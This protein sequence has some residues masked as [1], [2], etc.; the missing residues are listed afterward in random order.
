[1]TV[2][3]V[4]ARD[5]D[6]EIVRNLVTFYIYD[7]SEFGRWD[8]NEKGTFGLPAGIGNYWSGGEGPHWKPHWQGFPFLVRVD[9][10]IAGFALVKRIAESPPAY[11]MGEFFILRKFRRSGVGEQTACT[12]FNRFR[13]QWDVR[14]MPVNLPAQNF[15]RR[16]IARYTQNDFT[17]ARE[18]FPEYG[19]EF[20]IQRFQS[21]G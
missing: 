2:E 7:L 3:L 9:G 16:I 19:A 10:E 6:I 11:D 4:P 18:I 5:D 1:V 13:G 21:R 14:E 15:W 17:E 8:V 12:L 20:V